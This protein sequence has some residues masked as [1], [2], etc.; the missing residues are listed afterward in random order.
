MKSVSNVA[1]L[2]ASLIGVSTFSGG[3]NATVVALAD[4]YLPLFPTGPSTTVVGVQNATAPSQT[5]YSGGGYKISFNGVGS[6]QGIVQGSV[7]S[8]I[9]AVPVAGVTLPGGAPT[10]LTGDYGSSTTTNPLLSGNYLS[11]GTGSI[12]VTFDAPQISLGLLWGS[13]DLSN[14]VTFSNGDTLTGTEV[15]ALAAGFASNGFQGPGGSAY[16]VAVETV[17]F[18]SVTFSSDVTSFE[19]ASVVASVTNVTSVPLPGSAPMFGAALV[20]LGAIGYGVKRNKVK[21]AATL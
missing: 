13:I 5:T 6:D 11:T 1:L 19:L 12:T 14:S 8:T 7:P 18:T 10:Y 16:V 4:L 15:Q 9:H 17:P 20:A 21:P 2:T 3:A